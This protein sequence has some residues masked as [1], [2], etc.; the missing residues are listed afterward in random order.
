MLYLAP[1]EFREAFEVYR[2]VYIYSI[3]LPSGISLTSNN[4]NNTTNQQFLTLFF[5]DRLIFL[6]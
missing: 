5:C 6:H 2:I 1:D 4:S 3:V